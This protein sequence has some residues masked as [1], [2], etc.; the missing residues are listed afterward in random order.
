[1]TKFEVG[2]GLSYQVDATAFMKAMGAIGYKE[3]RSINQLFIWAKAD[4]KAQDTIVETGTIPSRT[5]KKLCDAFYKTPEY[6]G[7]DTNA[8]LRKRNA[9]DTRGQSD[10]AQSQHKAEQTVLPIGQKNE[11]PSRLFEA[12]SQL[13]LA[14]ENAVLEIRALKQSNAS[15]IH[16]LTMEVSNLHDTLKARPVIEPA[17]L[18]RIIEEGTDHDHT[19]DVMRGIKCAKDT[20]TDATFIGAKK[21]LFRKEEERNKK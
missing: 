10:D 16:T 19:D 2:R 5:L 20:L 9:D 13:T 18:K 8:P 17:V 12:I 15:C 4:R 14:V 3:G 7:V 6:F 21:A 11:E 1:M